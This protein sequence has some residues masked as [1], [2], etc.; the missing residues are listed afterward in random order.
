[1]RLD[2]R[3][4]LIGGLAVVL[5]VIVIVA[6]LMSSRPDTSQPNEFGLDPSTV[7]APTGPES[8]TTPEQTTETAQEQD[9]GNYF[10]T[11]LSVLNN[12]FDVGDKLF[13]NDTVQG[14]AL[15]HNFAL[16][17]LEIDQ[18][19][20]TQRSATEWGFLVRDANG[21]R[22]FYVN[23]TRLPEGNIKVEEFL[24]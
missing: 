11:N 13:I 2:K 20:F 15:N 24:Q 9:T 10:L 12:T 14:F 7:D 1:M 8:L 6:G 18:V 19:S 4:V 23:I 5:V 16:E 17:G 22:L 3:L 21:N